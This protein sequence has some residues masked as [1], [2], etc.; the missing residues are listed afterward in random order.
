MDEQRALSL[1]GLA[2]RAGHVTSGDDMAE[3]AVRAGRAALVLI[4]ADASVRTFGK[5]ESLCKGKRIQL[6]SISAGALGKS[7]GKDNRM[8]A[9]MTKGPL[10]N[11]VATLLTSERLP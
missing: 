5:Y 6:F 11:R 8:V 7:I 3:R 1:L 10:A 9:V 2:M 4:D